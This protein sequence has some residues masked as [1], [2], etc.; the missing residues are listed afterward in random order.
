TWED[1]LWAQISILCEEKQTAEMIKLGGG[2]WDE[3]L[4]VLEDLK[5][6]F[7]TVPRGRCS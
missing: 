5:Y 1:H 4:A 2:F 3:G 6:A 7:A